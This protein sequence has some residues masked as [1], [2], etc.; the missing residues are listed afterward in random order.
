MLTGRRPFKG[1]TPVQTALMHIKTP[2]TPP[3]EVNPMIPAPLD[4]LLCRMMAKRP[5]E[6]YQSTEELLAALEDLEAALGL[7]ESVLPPVAALVNQGLAD[8]D[9]V[10][11]S[12]PGPEGVVPPP[13]PGPGGEA[14]GDPATAVPDG[15]PGENPRVKWFGPALLAGAGLACIVLI[16]VLVGLLGGGDGNGEG[17]V[18]DAP[19]GNN[20]NHPDPPPGNNRPPVHPNADDEPAPLPEPNQ[21][22]EQMVR[23]VERLW[24]ARRYLEAIR[25]LETFIEEYEG[26]QRAE[27]A[28]QMLAERCAELE[29]LCQQTYEAKRA[30]AAQ[31][32]AAGRYG[33]AI[34][35]FTEDGQLQRQAGERLQQ[36]IE[37]DI[38]NYREQAEA[39]VGAALREAEAVL[40]TSPPDYFRARQLLRDA[41]CIGIPEILTPLQERLEAV[42]ADIQEGQAARNQVLLSHLESEAE[43]A[44]WLV[45]GCLPGLE[46][47]ARSPVELRGGPDGDRG[48]ARRRPRG[49]PLDAA[50]AQAGVGGPHRILGDGPGRAGGPLAPP[51]AP[52][53]PPAAGAEPADAPHRRGPRRDGLRGARGQRHAGGAARGADAGDGVHAGGRRLGT[54]SGGS[55]VATTRRPSPWGC[56]VCSTG[57]SCPMSCGV[58]TSPRTRPGGSRTRDRCSARTRPWRTP[59]R[60]GWRPSTG[61]WH[62]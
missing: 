27:T 29:H 12:G 62:P 41:L 48:A 13:L 4:A 51:G 34:G 14:P 61:R 50:A 54:A 33:N 20:N 49:P 6:R 30:L 3:R 11:A 10:L 36:L 25:R 44:R 19:S 58:L 15:E 43:T 42:D 37:R 2:L 28:A 52:H 39:A 38:A 45:R 23:D 60:R 26:T 57:R 47:K 55:S 22:F 21:Q 17:P 16:V 59:T 53:V 31:D 46:L 40:S 56:S 5:E 24:R 8:G 32:A 1:D 18:T 7:G 9:T 35:R